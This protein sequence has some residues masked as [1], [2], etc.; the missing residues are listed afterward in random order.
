VTKPFNLRELLARVRAVLRRRR[1]SVR[2][3][4]KRPREGGRVRF[5]GWQVDRGIRSLTDPTGAAVALT[6]REYALLTAFLDAPQRPLTR[7][8]VL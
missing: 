7:E 8:Y 3:T 1:E 5:D 6:K 4:P 2:V